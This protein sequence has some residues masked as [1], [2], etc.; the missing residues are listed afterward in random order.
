VTAVSPVGTFETFLRDTTKFSRLPSQ[1]EV[2]KAFE[3]GG[4]TV[5]GP[6]LEID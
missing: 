1:E 2:E 5:V 6:P 3:V 4:M